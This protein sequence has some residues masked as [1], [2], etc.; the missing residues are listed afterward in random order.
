MIFPIPS[1]P[2]VSLCLSLL[3]QCICARANYQDMPFHYCH[4][5]KKREREGNKL[6]EELFSLPSGLLTVVWQTRDTQDTTFSLH[7]TW[8]D[9]APLQRPSSQTKHPLHNLNHWHFSFQLQDKCVRSFEAAQCFQAFKDSQEVVNMSSEWERKMINGLW[10]LVVSCQMDW[11]VYFRNCWCSGIF[12]YSYLWFLQ[13]IAW[14]IIWQ[15]FCGWKFLNDVR[16]EWPEW[17]EPIRKA[18]LTQITTC[19]N[20][21]LIEQMSY[22]SK[23]NHT[24]D[25]PV[26]WEQ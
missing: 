9:H 20:W 5:A 1:P 25:T 8:T 2:H 13:R 22:I 3:P 17:F 26:S 6:I 14:K 21:D 10:T 15:E 24:G 23:N 11:S 16:E 19:Y 4:K 18:T 12:L 7:F